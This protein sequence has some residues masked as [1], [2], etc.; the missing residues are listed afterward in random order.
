MRP[1][2]PQARMPAAASFP[3]VCRLFAFTPGCKH[4][5]RRQDASIPSVS[6]R[7]GMS[8]DSC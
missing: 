2:Q 4:S 8:Q 5:S 3:S 1:R 7:Q 6:G